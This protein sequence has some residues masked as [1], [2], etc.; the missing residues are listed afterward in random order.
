MFKKRFVKKEREQ[1]Y[2]THIFLIFLNVFFIFLQVDL[3]CYKNLVTA[4]PALLTV[5][6]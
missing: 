4:T 6:D 3:L 2:A 5:K 1:N